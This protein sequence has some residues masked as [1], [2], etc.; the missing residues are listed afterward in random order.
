MCR[1]FKHHRSGLYAWLETHFSDHSVEDLRL[2]KR[3]KEFYVASG[4][5]YGSPGFTKIFVMR[6]RRAA[7]IA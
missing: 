5:T 4:G 3:I 2:L 7:F 6:S 1:V